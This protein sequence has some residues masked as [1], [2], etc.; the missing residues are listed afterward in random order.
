MP[1][2]LQTY[3]VPVSGGVDE[4]TDPINLPRGRL[5]SAKNVRFTKDGL[6]QKRRGHTVLSSTSDATGGWGVTGIQ[7][8]EGRLIAGG[9]RLMLADG[10]ALHQYAVN[11]SKEWA[12]KCLLPRFTG[13]S[14]SAASSTKV[15]AHSA[16]AIATSTAG[17][18][19]IVVAYTEFQAPPTWGGSVFC[20]ILDRE[21]GAE[22]NTTG[23]VGNSDNTCQL[24]AG[25]LD[26]HG[27]QLVA[28]GTSTL[29]RVVA[30]YS[31]HSSG[32]IYYRAIDVDTMAWGAEVVCGVSGLTGSGANRFDA[33]PLLGGVALV[34]QDTGYVVKAYKQTFTGTSL[35]LQSVATIQD[36]SA[37]PTIATGFGITPNQ[38]ADS[39]PYVWVSY[40]YD[41]SFGVISVARP[42][43]VASWTAIGAAPTTLKFYSPSNSA[44]GDQVSASC[45]A[46]DPDDT[47]KANIG[48]SLL[49]YAT[50]GLSLV[51]GGHTALYS[52]FYSATL[53]LPSAVTS[54][55]I[56]YFIRA[57]IVST[58]FK[59]AGRWFC[60]IER[61]SGVHISGATG[62][63]VF[64]NSAYVGPAST[65][66][67][68]ASTFVVDIS[69]RVEDCVFFPRQS[70]ILPDGDTV[71]G[72][73]R[74]VTQYVAPDDPVFVVCVYDSLQRRCS[75][76][77]VELSV[78]DRY[79]Y[80]SYATAE[81]DVIAGG[82]VG[83]MD[84]RSFFPCGFPFNSNYITYDE[85]AGVALSAGTSAALVWEYI[86]N[87]GNVQYSPSSS[88]LDLSGKKLPVDIWFPYG[89]TG[90]DAYNSKTLT[91]GTQTGN[92]S[93][94]LYAGDTSKSMYEV[95]RQEI[96][97]EVVDGWNGGVSVFL[98][99]VS[100][101]P[102]TAQDGKQFIYTQGGVLDDVLPPASIGMCEYRGRIICIDH[103]RRS[104]RISH[105]M[106]PGERPRFSDDITI[107]VPFDA[108]ALFSHAG[109]CYVF[110]AQQIGVFNGYGPNQLGDGEQFPPIEIISHDIGIADSRS[111]VRTP[112]GI[113]FQS[114]IGMCRLGSNG[115]EYVGSAVMDTLTSY[116]VVTSAVQHP[117]E[118]V[119]LFTVTNGSTAGARLVYDYR[120]DRWSV[121]DIFG[122][123]IISQAV[124]NGSVYLLTYDGTVIFE[125]DVST[126]AGLW[127]T[128]ELTFASEK[129]SGAQS[130]HRFR[131]VG[132]L[133]SRLG[134]CDVNVGVAY[135]DAATYEYVQTFQMN[136]PDSDDVDVQ[137]YP[138]RQLARSIRVRITDAT[139]TGEGFDGGVTGAGI[140]VSGIALTAGVYGGINRLDSG[141]MK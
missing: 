68:E 92:M 58:P 33:K 124:F 31:D 72:F 59:S 127:I 77:V 110:G 84:V 96:T 101:Q 65:A 133:G 91:A 12:T 51:N 70:Y 125:D 2:Q 80:Q 104:L 34:Y 40:G 119:V 117:S 138:A 78:D 134:N 35:T 95:S 64:G 123:A 37:S 136:D 57:K 118:P 56:A 30:Y 141:K 53:T 19:Y 81:G 47:S 6:A 137:F 99:G 23:A 28:I 112:A 55:P 36:L 83:Y 63:N 49:T 88:V 109:V 135:D 26:C 66:L 132:L 29:N 86:D 4:G 79:R 89:L 130:Q 62:F 8:G 94:V 113:M 32:L 52:D 116:P 18:E 85:G 38:F 21:T 114:S 111:I 74:V 5:V 50:N 45:S 120:L 46:V 103:T 54:E 9:E 3:H 90:W 108:E 73:I 121:D 100:A 93:A 131:C 76:H 75:C 60:V 27:I 17:R 106:I 126:D 97:T 67:N 128:Q 42:V 39:Y 82:L 122:V 102:G 61:N 129:P 11:G 87:D 69:T 48:F 107:D 15:I 7:S 14:K 25:A 139:P 41:N 43:D 1:I 140:K 115:V 22:V 24:N 105:V 44:G 13:T 20:K 98:S 10:R 71:Y 16:Q